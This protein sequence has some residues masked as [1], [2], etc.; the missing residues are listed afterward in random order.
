MQGVQAELA[1][2]QEESIYEGIRKLMLRGVLVRPVGGGR[3]G[4]C[5][6]LL[7]SFGFVLLVFV[8]IV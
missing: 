2:E 8:V 5:G 4:I 6:F 1:Q 7:D 3:G